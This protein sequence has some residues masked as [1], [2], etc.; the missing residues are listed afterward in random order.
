MNRPK[1]IYLNSNTNSRAMRRVVTKSL[2][3]KTLT[4]L[5]YPV[6]HTRRIFGSQLYL[7]ELSELVYQMNFYY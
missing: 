3:Y 5:L 7:A 6:D 1:R 4:L 2:C